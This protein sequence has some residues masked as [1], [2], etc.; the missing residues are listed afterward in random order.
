MIIGM[1]V[2]FLFLTLLVFVMGLLAGICRK[3]FPE[4]EEPAAKKT[5]VGG[6]DAE[7]AVAIA[8]ANAYSKS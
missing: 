7:I 8:A 4:I 3:F 1:S 6:S 2:V 5:A